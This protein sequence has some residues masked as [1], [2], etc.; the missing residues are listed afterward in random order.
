MTV[1]GLQI[2]DL[3]MFVKRW[4]GGGLQLTTCKNYK[5]GS[6][7]VKLFLDNTL[8]EAWR[9]CANER[10]GS[11]KAAPVKQHRWRGQERLKT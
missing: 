11:G 2:F 5:Q 6:I 10:L 3:M 9:I 7:I 8:T 4:G 1:F